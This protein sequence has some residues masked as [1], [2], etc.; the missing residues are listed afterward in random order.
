MVSFLYTRKF[1]KIQ[2]FIW[3]EKN[4]NFLMRTISQII[5]F[6]SGGGSSIIISIAFCSFI[7]YTGISATMQP[8]HSLLLPFTSHDVHVLKIAVLSSGEDFD[9]IQRLYF[10]KR[11]AEEVA[12]K[13]SE[14]NSSLDG[15]SFKTVKTKAAVVAP[16]EKIAELNKQRETVELILRKQCIPQFQSPYQ[17][18]LASEA[19]EDDSEDFNSFFDDQNVN[20]SN[21]MLGLDLCTPGASGLLK[22]SNV[23][24]IGLKNPNF[25][26]AECGIR[27]DPRPNTRQGYDPANFEKWNPILKKSRSFVELPSSPKDAKIQDAQFVDHDEDRLSSATEHMARAMRNAQKLATPNSANSSNNSDF[28]DAEDFEDAQQRQ[29]TRQEINL[30]MDRLKMMVAASEEN[31]ISPSSVWGLLRCSVPFAVRSVMGGAMH[32]FSELSGLVKRDEVASWEDSENAKAIWE[33]IFDE[34]DD[35]ETEEDLV[36][37][38]AIFRSAVEL[39]KKNPTSQ[40]PTKSFCPGLFEKFTVDEVQDVLLSAWKRF[41]K[42]GKRRDAEARDLCD[43]ILELANKCSLVE[44]LSKRSDADYLVSILRAR[45]APAPDFDVE[46]ESGCDASVYSTDLVVM[47]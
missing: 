36:D 24:V 30:A 8:S 19:L 32:R 9:V 43:T 33:K 35:A 39:C 47:A 14:M 20:T 25:S 31:A 23:S 29:W 15:R 37:V 41:A 42:S 22:I 11:S 13:W 38:V 46:S 1:K 5:A 7:R 27:V 16:V 2:M 44:S 4:L 3:R 10:P 28:E 12:R 40:D 18:S 21:Q 26:I 6:I 45:Y 17:N 34:I